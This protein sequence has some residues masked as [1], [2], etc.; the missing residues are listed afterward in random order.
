MCQFTIPFTADP[1]SLITRAKQEIKKTGGAFEGD[2]TQ[3]SFRA[4]TPIG[5]IEGSY[6]IEG[7]QIFLSVTKKPF[8]LS[9]GRIQ[10][11]LSGIMV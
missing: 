8:L 2:V 9:C 3:G 1:T 10:K 5:S 7:Q 6:Q 4:K 11:E